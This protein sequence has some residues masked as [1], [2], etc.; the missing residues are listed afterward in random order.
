MTEAQN[1]PHNFDV[2]ATIAAATA[3]IG[4]SRA[5]G[6]SQ[7]GECIMSAQRWIRAGGGAWLGGGDPVTNYTGALRLSPADAEAGDVIQYEYLS[8]P[9]SWVSGIHTV[10]ITGVNDDGTFKIIES[11]NPAGSG[12]VSANDSWVPAPP[13]GFQAVAWRF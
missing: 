3:E 8:S 12:L 13:A 10:L 7:Q 9:S 1:S 4:T 11:N 5:T 6:W 2:E